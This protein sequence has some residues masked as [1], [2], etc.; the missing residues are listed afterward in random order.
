MERSPRNPVYRFDQTPSTQADRLRREARGTPHG[1]RRDELIRRAQQIEGLPSL[2][3]P[4]VS[5]DLR[6]FK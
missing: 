5:L 4:L 2:Q 6:L 3:E 1:V